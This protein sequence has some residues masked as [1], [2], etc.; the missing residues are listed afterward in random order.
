MLFEF[1]RRALHPLTPLCHLMSKISPP[2]API[3]LD[4]KTD[5]TTGG[6][7]DYDLGADVECEQQSNV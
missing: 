1:K 5:R 4:E 6:N 3:T 2:Q 7:L